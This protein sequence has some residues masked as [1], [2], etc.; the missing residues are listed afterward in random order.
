[1]SDIQ[2]ISI[3]STKEVDTPKPHT[4]YVIQGLL[5]LSKKKRVMLY[6]LTVY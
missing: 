4:V 5:P 6:I 1:M 2:D 3:I